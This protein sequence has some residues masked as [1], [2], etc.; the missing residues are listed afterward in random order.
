M[1][2]IE[3]IETRF[4]EITGLPLSLDISKFPLTEHI[5]FAIRSKEKQELGEVFTPLH[6]VDKMIGIAKPEPTKFNMD[7]CAGHGQ[8]TVRMLRKF[9]NDNPDFAIESYLKD[10]HWFNEFNVKSALDLLYI[11]GENINLA[12]GPAQELKN[13]PQD[14]TKTWRRGIFYYEPSIKRWIKSDLKELE[15]ISMATIVTEKKVHSKQL[16]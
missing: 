6:L 5:G 7:L 15:K 8:F 1:N 9:K 10:L 13:F 14:E 11:F 4:K 16:F 3:A 2:L 12:V